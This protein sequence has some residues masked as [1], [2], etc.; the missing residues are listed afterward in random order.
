MANFMYLHY[1]GK[2]P[3]TFNNYFVINES[4]HS[5]NIRQLQ[6]YALILKEQIME[7]F[8]VSIEE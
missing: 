4:I 1:Y 3:E 2:L 5:Y 6:K 8:L 7:K